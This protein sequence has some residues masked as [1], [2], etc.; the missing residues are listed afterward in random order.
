MPAKS[1]KLNFD[2]LRE[3]LFRNAE[4]C[5]K[6]SICLNRVLKG[7]RSRLDER[8]LVGV[9]NAVSS[10]VFSLPAAAPSR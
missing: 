6:I 10:R 5:G 7:R 3:A 2:H 8:F 9:N 4:K 1:F